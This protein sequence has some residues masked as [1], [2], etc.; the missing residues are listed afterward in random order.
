MKKLLT[1]FADG[2]LTKEQMKK[3]KGGYETVGCPDG[4]NYATEQV[5]NEKCKA[6]SYA[7]C[8]YSSTRM[9]YQCACYD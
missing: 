9:E 8:T 7:K 5:C 1:R 6:K 3:V 2:L 4:V